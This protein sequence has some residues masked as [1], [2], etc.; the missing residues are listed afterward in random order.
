[1]HQSRAVITV[2]ASA[3]GTP[4][5]PDIFGIF[6]EDLNHAADGG[7]YAELVRN[8]SFSYSE[9]DRTD[10]HSLTGWELIGAAGV[11]AGADGRPYAELRV[12]DPGTAAGLR[13]GG[14][15]GIAITAGARYTVR[16]LARSVAGGPAE[17][18]ALLETTVGATLGAVTVGTVASDEW[19]WYTGTVEATSTDPD[20]R[21]TIL[22]DTRGSLH[23][24]FVS[25]FPEA[26]YR[27]RPNGLRADLAQAI[28]DLKPKFVRFPGGC[29][30]HGDGLGNMY[31]WKDTLGPLESRRT[32]RNLWGYHQ[33]AGLGYF[34]YFQFCED[35]GAKPLPV[36][37]AG[38]CCQ[39]TPGGQQ[40]IGEEDMPAYIEEVL[41]LVEYANGPAD[42]PWGSVRAAAGHPEPFGLEY[43]GIGNE[44]LITPAFKDRFARIHEA[45][46]EHH[47]E[48]TLIGTAGPSP[49]G[50]EWEA[51]WDFARK[52]GVEVV[53]EHA[54]KSPRWFLENTHRFDDLDR[55]GPKVYVGE[56]AARSN[57]MLSALAEATFMIAMERAG[58]V[59]Q[60]SS[61]APLLAK[62]GNTQWV[63]D[64]IYFDNTRVHKTL[65]YHVQQMHSVNSGDTRLPLT[66]SGGPADPAR[67]EPDSDRRGISLGTCA[68]RAEFADIRVNGSA[69]GG[70]EPLAGTWEAVEGV[71]RQTDDDGQAVAVLAATA[72]AGDCV[73]TL[74]ARRTGGAEGFIVG[75]GRTA[76]GDHYQWNLGGWKNL[77]LTLQR[78][79]D[80]IVHDLVD[81]VPHPME[82]G[83]WYDVRIELRGSHIRCF[84]DGTPVHDLVDVRRAPERFAVSSVRDSRTGDVIVKVANTTANTVTTVL[85]LRTQDERFPQ[86][87]ATVLTADPDDGKPFA[88]APADPVTVA[89]PPSEPAEHEL[90]PYS[91]TVFR[92]TRHPAS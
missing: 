60:L 48:L 1:M 74:R 84:L 10:W 76:P 49:V 5:S 7:L 37:A 30:V 32:Q 53:D 63:P 72:P 85:D 39:N 50:D 23:L 34:E 54:Y 44:D 57:T 89:L 64:L 52:L 61:Y 71:L 3:A 51:G 18:T 81:P 70:W 87:T 36:V 80:T 62:V 14:F 69:S 17:L 47:P 16:V 59:V 45:L 73:I 66:V 35:I 8:R 13:N 90:P 43:L 6:F 86:V 26:T 78:S 4:I 20:A 88:P 79:D 21:F 58:D 75:F 27:N 15:G 38:V 2:D 12:G 77:S 91:F 19:T 31:R 68:S 22:A 24:A 29:L 42:S 56:Y 33:S 46:R 83:R 9:D 25:L 67:P 28:A 41:D 82:T 92:A 55:S 65:N 40:A 11:T